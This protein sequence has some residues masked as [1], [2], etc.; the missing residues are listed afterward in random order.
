MTGFRKRSVQALVSGITHFLTAAKSEESLSIRLIVRRKSNMGNGNEQNTKWKRILQTDW[1][2]VGMLHVSVAPEQHPP[3]Q[4]STQ[5]RLCRTGA[6]S[7]AWSVAKGVLEKEAE[8]RGWTKHKEDWLGN[9]N[10]MRCCTW[11]TVHY[12][13]GGN[14]SIIEKPNTPQNARSRG[15]PTDSIFLVAFKILHHLH[16]CSPRRFVAKYPTTWVFC[17][18]LDPS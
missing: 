14:T 7:H 9:M 17:F 1:L 12:Q 6:R 2:N 5:L 11:A 4:G 13:G 8:A 10:Q 18:R 16:P 3:G 15:S